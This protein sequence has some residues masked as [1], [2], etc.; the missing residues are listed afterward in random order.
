MYFVSDS[1]VVLWIAYISWQCI[2]FPKQERGNI[3]TRCKHTHLLECLWGTDLFW[4]SERFCRTRVSNIFLKGKKLYINEII[5]FNFFSKLCQFYNFTRF[6]RFTRFKILL[7]LRKEN[8]YNLHRYL[9]VFY[10][11]IKLFYA[12]VSFA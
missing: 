11:Q 5:F 3:L 8:N 1:K 4:C 10:N 7:I 2:K 6:T 9:F 12:G